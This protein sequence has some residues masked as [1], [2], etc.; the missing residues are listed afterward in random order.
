MQT[1]AGDFLK[2]IIT[3]SANA[4]GQDTSVIGPNE[5]TRQLVSQGCIDQLLKEMLKGGNPLTVGVGII[6]EVIRKNNS[7]YDSDTQIGPEPRSSDPIYLGCLLRTF[8]NHVPDFMEL[9]LSKNHTVI[10]EQGSQ[11]ILRKDLSTA[12]GSKIEPLGFDRFKTC[13]LMAELLH[14]SNMALL[15][16]RGSEAEVAKRDNERER[17][18]AEGQLVSDRSQQ[19]NEDFAASVDSSGFHHAE[20]FSPVG[21]TAEN[22]RAG[23]GST[24]GIE[25]DFEKVNISEVDMDATAEE[26]QETNETDSR[27]PR[28][29][30]QRRSSLLTEQLQA[31]G[32]RAFT[33]Q[34]VSADD[35]SSDDSDKPA[36]LFSKRNVVSP[37]ASDSTDEPVLVPSEVADGLEEE[38]SDVKASDLDNIEEDTS[39]GV[40]READGSPVIGDLL[41]MMFVEHKVVPTIIVRFC[42]FS[43]HAVLTRAGLLLPIPLEQLSP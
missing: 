37:P 26:G 21:D 17:L 25:E 15:N 3:I 9:I 7:D 10:T 14:C 34:S 38:D 12:W 18:K 41:K 29:A 42:T 33:H 35:T 4:T 16:E 27:R 20:A 36:P 1:A 2:A 19:E 11:T 31:E 24:P 30:N 5:L 13:E 23:D 32:E 22:V 28:F 39:P 43:A 8:A 40:Q 6:I